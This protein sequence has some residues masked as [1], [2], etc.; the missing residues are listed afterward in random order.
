MLWPLWQVGLPT[1]TSPTLGES[2]GGDTDFAG[3]LRLARGES[4]MTVSRSDRS[5]V[6]LPDPGNV[7]T[8]DALTEALRLLKV[9]AGEPSYDTITERINVARKVAGGRGGR[10]ARRSTVADCFKVGRRRLDTEL[11]IAVV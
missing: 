5:L 3:S 4:P 9:W 7:G 6:V 2:P 8:L 11:V 10:W 1:E